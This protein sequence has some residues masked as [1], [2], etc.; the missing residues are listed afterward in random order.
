NNFGCQEDFSSSLN[1]IVFSSQFI[2]SIS[3]LILICVCSSLIF[4]SESNLRRGSYDLPFKK[5]LSLI[6]TYFL[7][8]TYQPVQELQTCY[9][10]FS[11]VKN[12]CLV[13]AL[14]KVRNLQNHSI[15]LALWFHQYYLNG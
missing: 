15:F 14:L 2:S 9:S 1:F 13:L 10:K 4:E 7:S 12:L 11:R 6:V 3:L 8:Q 5:L